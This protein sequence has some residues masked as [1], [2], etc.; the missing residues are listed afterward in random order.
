MSDNYFQ[1]F[2][3]LVR[4]EIDF[5]YNDIPIPP[6]YSDTSNWAALPEKDAQQF[7]VPDLSLIH[8]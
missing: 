6:D 8:I 2:L 1:K 5:N 4:P 7:Y 3:E